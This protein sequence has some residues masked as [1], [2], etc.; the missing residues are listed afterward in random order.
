MSLQV[1]L[2]LNGNL[3]NLGLTSIDFITSGVT[4]ADGG[5]IGQKYLSAGTI[6]IPAIKS[7]NIFNN[8]NMSFAFWIYP[9][10]TSG[11][12]AIM[13]QTSMATGD[14]RMYTIYQ[15][16]TPNDLHLS[17][18][19]ETATNSATFLGGVWSGFFPANT[20]THCCITYNGSVATIYRNGEKYSTASGSQNRQNFE[21][22]FPINGSTVRR[23][24][25]VRIYN[26]CLSPK[27]VE[28]ISKGL[29]LHYKLDN[30]GLSGFNFLTYSSLQYK[31][32]NFP[33]VNSAYTQTF[34]KI[35]GYDCFHI[36]SETLNV[37]ASFGWNV[38]DFIN[39]YPIGTKFTFSGWIKTDNITKGTTNYFSELYYGGSYNN[40][41][42]STWIGEGSRI[43]TNIN[44]SAFNLSGQGWVYCYITSTFTRNDYT[45]MSALYY[46]RDWTGD[47]YL[48]NFKLEVGDKPTIWSPNPSDLGLDTSVIYDSS[49][50]N[51][52]G[53]IINDLQIIS[54]SPRY[55]VA[56]NLTTTSSHI[57]VSNLSVDGFSNSYTFTWWGNCSTYSGKMMWGFSD[58]ARLNGIYNGNLWNT[59]DGSNNPL[60]APGTTTQVSAPSV[61]V[62]HHFAMVGD[63]TQ[64]LAYLDGILWGQAKTYKTISGTSIYFN[65]WDSGTSYTLANTKISDFRIYSTALTANQIKEL[66]DTSVSVGSFGN[67][68]ARE[69]VEQ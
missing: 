4:F 34:E 1:W 14:N 30:N 58:G 29:M 42:T 36:H 6:T 57:H 50:Y 2:P 11:S 26:H 43:T 44:S 17:W 3:D 32:N 37:S 25:D 66:Y 28:E 13:G 45:G 38:K 20:W 51:N 48:R 5:K 22:N 54:D 31:I 49:G 53:E 10:G 69:V 9:I 7:K 21:Y 65:G 35:D 27:E 8:D 24:N 59:G 55:S 67:I 61:N 47:I 64:C 23:L 12:G 39:Q 15:Y 68:Y 56:T 40:N 62:W 60:Y 41:G 33:S 16:S 52:N 18:Q 63:G 19:N 46:L